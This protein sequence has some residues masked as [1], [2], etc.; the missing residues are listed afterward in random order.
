[1]TRPPPTIVDSTA[2]KL[3][4][5]TALLDRVAGAY[6]RDEH[7]IRYP[8]FL[9]LLMVRVLDEPSQ[10]RIATN[11]GVTRASVTQRLT[12]LAEQ[13]LLAIRTDPADSRANLVSLTPRGA[14]LLDAAW[15]GLEAHRAGLDLGVDEVALV[16]Q[17]DRILAN[18]ARLEAR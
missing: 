17:L 14:A 18:G 12:P 2:F 9:V 8:A 3:H 7:D 13:G 16:V 6:L 11:L 1:M 10:R 15:R 4:R 5:V